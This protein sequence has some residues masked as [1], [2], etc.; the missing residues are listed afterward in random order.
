M[1]A[2]SGLEPP[3]D[4]V[5]ALFQIARRLRQ[6]TGPAPVDQAGLV[7]LHRIA[8]GEG[9]RPTDLATDLGLDASTVS[10]HLRGLAD[11]GLVERADD[12]GD[13]RAQ[14]VTLSPAGTRVLAEALDRRR[15]LLEAAVADWSETDRQALTS[16]L[17]RLARALDEA[18][19]PAGAKP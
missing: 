9:P 5:P 10:R 16:L 12:P 7:V 18:A 3:D 14:R 15:A 6:A 11:L 8:C 4:L 19:E 13:R 1:H 2:K 17:V